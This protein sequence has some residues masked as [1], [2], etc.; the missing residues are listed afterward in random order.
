MSIVKCPYCEQRF[1]RNEE[2]AVLVGNRWYHS[3]CLRRKELD[4]K[5]RKKIH[6]KVKNMCGS[7]YSSARINKQIKQFVEDGMTI[8]GIYKSLQY[9]YDI[10]GNDPSQANGGIGIVPYIYEDMKKYF[11][12]QKMRKKSMEALGEHVFKEI[13]ERNKLYKPQECKIPKD[14][15]QSRPHHKQ[16]FNLE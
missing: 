7:T 1:D 16:L 12:Q 8:P 4:T 11:E 5:Y 14:A 6:E 9:W 3:E 2:P 13:E 10:K 15:R